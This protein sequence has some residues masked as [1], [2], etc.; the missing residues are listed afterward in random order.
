MVICCGVDVENGVDE[1]CGKKVSVRDVDDAIN[2][3][4]GDT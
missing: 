4:L 1:D 2:E 3:L